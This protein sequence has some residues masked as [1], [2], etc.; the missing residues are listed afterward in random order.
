MIDVNINV[1]FLCSQAFGP[2]MVKQVHGGSI[3]QIS[4]IYGI[5]GTD[6]RIYE[7]SNHIR[8]RT[9]NPASYIKFVFFTQTVDY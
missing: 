6:H 4:S 5:R 3:I 7:K 1:V 9:N 2:V 8:V